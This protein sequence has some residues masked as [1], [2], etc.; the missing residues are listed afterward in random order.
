[1]SK[2]FKAGKRAGYVDITTRVP[3][4]ALRYLKE[5]ALKSYGGM[6][7]DMYKIMIE[8]WFQRE[9]WAKGFPWRKTQALSRRE[10]VEEIREHPDGTKMVVPITVTRATGWV[11]VN[12]RIPEALNERVRGLAF[13]YGE[14]PSTVLYTIIF[15]W[16]WWKNPPPEVAAKR[17]RER[18]E[19]RNARATA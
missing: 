7:T 9:L 8:E 5:L 17:A 12:M 3:S 11:Q 16:T 14:S 10:V 4:P 18:E 13:Q 2:R 1:M 6:L 19:K 15:W